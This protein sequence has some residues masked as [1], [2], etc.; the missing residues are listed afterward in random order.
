[1]PYACKCS[2][3]SVW[4]LW[5]DLAHLLKISTNWFTANTLKLCKLR[6]NA[7]LTNLLSS[8]NSW[9]TANAILNSP[10]TELLIDIAHT[11]TR[12]LEEGLFFWWICHMEKVT[13]SCGFR[14]ERH[15][16]Q[17]LW[18]KIAFYL[19]KC[20]LSTTCDKHADLEVDIKSLKNICLME[21]SVIIIVN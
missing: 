14:K 6:L 2:G 13:D 4:T 12:F 16:K 20:H 19:W 17:G 10:E 8:W 1:M 5:T 15:C 21:N 9:M 18:E 11:H 7:S 3:H